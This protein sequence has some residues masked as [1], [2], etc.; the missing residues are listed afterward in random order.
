MQL[1]LKKWWVI[2]I[3]GI[4]LIILSIYVFNHPGATLLGLTFWISILIFISGLAGIA[5]WLFANAEERDT[6]GLLWSVASTLFGLLLITK[7]GFAMNLLTNLL[8]FWMILTGGWLMQ[9]GWTSKH[10]SSIGWIV[11]IIGLL[12]VIAGL[13]VMFNIAAGAI[14][15]STLI[16]IQFLIAGIALII[17]SFVKKKIVSVVKDKAAEI[18]SRFEHS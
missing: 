12:S 13:M 15:V 9:Q 3:Q 10:N 4:L 2:L 16:G 18:R 1:L 17:L 5:G 11:F 6:S 7:I 8:G 14:A